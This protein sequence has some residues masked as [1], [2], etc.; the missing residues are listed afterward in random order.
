[1]TN[2]IFTVYSF[3]ELYDKLF[4][5]YS[6][7]P[8]NAE[9]LIHNMSYIDLLWSHHEVVSLF[10]RYKKIK[11]FMKELINIEF[12]S[13]NNRMFLRINF[14]LCENGKWRKTHYYTSDIWTIGYESS[15]EFKD[16]DTET[17]LK[18]RNRFK[19]SGDKKEFLNKIYSEN[20]ISP[21]SVPIHYK[22]ELEKHRS[23]LE[24]YKYSYII[25]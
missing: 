20:C 25:E 10:N 16:M 15:K 9:Q 5:L 7:P 23:Y 19:A 11:S 6:I 14:K 22:D 4:N 21:L 24:K 1:M 2:I 13:K 12:Y 17:L 8:T 18:E 3:N